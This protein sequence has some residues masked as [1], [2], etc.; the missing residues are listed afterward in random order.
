MQ[1]AKDITVFNGIT[2]PE[3]ATLVGYGA[4]IDALQLQMLIPHKLA[5]ISK[6]HKQ[7]STENWLVY[8]PRHQPKETLFHQ[9][10]FALKYE[11]INLLFFKTVF[12]K[13]SEEE[14]MK[15]LQVE[16]TGQY[17]RKIWFLY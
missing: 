7:Y 4:I 13:I 1:F 3:P 8:T 9:L 11:G 14:V 10:V 15:V 16:P 6:K 17:T 5:I 2:T 12:Q